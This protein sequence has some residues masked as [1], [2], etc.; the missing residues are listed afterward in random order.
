M[1]SASGER[2]LVSR[3]PGGDWGYRVRSVLLCLPAEEWGPALASAHLRALGSLA[4]FTEFWHHHKAQS[5]KE[6]FFSQC[7]WQKQRKDGWETCF[8]TWLIFSSRISAAMET[9]ACFCL[10]KWGL[11]LWVW[12]I[13]TERRRWKVSLKNLRISANWRLGGLRHSV[14]GSGNYA[15]SLQKL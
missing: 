7:R 12:A 10:V 1:D 3:S 6:Q 13:C 2:P 14:L 11:F 8:D 15:S 9:S 5:P 4:A